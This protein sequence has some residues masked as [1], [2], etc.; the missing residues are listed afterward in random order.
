MAKIVKIAEAATNSRTTT[1]RSSDSDF[2]MKETSVAIESAY[3]RR[4]LLSSGSV[5][6]LCDESRNRGQGALIG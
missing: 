3:A 4:K 6:A 1:L 2:G 5:V